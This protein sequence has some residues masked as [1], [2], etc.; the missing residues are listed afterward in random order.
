MPTVEKEIAL[1]PVLLE[2]MHLKI[3]GV[4]PL[5]MN[6]FSDRE[7]QEMVN[8][9]LRKTKQ[10]SARDIELEIEEKIHRLP[11]ETIGFPSSGFKKAMVEAAPYLTGLNMKLA[12]GCFNILGE[13]VPI[14]YREQKINEAVVK[15]GK[16]RDK[17]AMVRFRPEFG[18]WSCI[19]HIRY[20]VNQISPEQI[21]NLANLAGFHI[22]V[23]DW[24]P[25]HNGQYGMFRI[26]INDKKEKER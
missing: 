16:G 12:K 20:N 7:K 3:E 11:D 2:D 22:G 10:K 8:K 13:L 19:L 23:G 6:K 24:T 9:Q 5:L 1:S 18:G 4:T 15:I 14:E 26:A 21:V 25:Q 17:I